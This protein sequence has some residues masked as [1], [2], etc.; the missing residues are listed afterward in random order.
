MSFLNPS[1]LWLS[2]LAVPLIALYALRVRP[3]RVEVATTMFWG[4]SHEQKPLRGVGNHLRDVVSLVLQL[5]LLALLTTALAEPQFYGQD[6]ATRQV[7][8]VLDN[9]ASMNATDVEP[10]RFEAARGEA[11]RLVNRLGAE[12][13]VAIITAGGAPRL[14]C[15][16]TRLR[17]R[18][19]RAIAEIQASQLP[20]QVG[21]ALL[22]AT[23][24]PS[25]GHRQVV[26][27]TDKPVEEVGQQEVFDGLSVIQVGG[28]TD[29]MAIT[30]FQARRSFNDPLG[31]QVLVA[32]QN[33]S[34]QPARCRLVLTLNGAMVD[35]VPLELSPG[36]TWKRVLAESAAEGG[37]LLARIEHEDALALDNSA[38][39]MLPDRTI[40]RVFL[41][42]P[43]N[44]FLKRVLEAQ[45][46]VELHVVDAIPKELAP[47]DV[48]VLHQQPFD[49]LP[50]GRVLVIEPV[51][52]TPDWNS[53]AL[54]D[55]P[56]VAD[57][58]DSLLLQHVDLGD[59]A[60]AGSRE[61]ELHTDAEILAHN[62]SGDPLLFTVRRNE[63]NALVM[64]LALE[65][66]DLPLRTAF[67]VLIANALTW[68]TDAAGELQDTYQLGEFVELPT[69]ELPATV[70]LRSP[71]GR[72]QLQE[73]RK[74]GPLIGP[75]DECGVWQI[76][77][78][79]PS[80]N[81]ATTLKLACNLSDANES[82]LLVEKV[83]R[84]KSASLSSTGLH[85]LWMYVVLATVC[86]SLTEWFLYHRRWIK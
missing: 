40:R 27:I 71:S 73:M 86:L 18:V 44:L 48:L 2:L 15:R 51:N 30:Q 83:D 1:A 77:V 23:E 32:V 26:V 67:P 63:G 69:N 4:T 62:P 13:E 65:Q 52:S 7:V 55:A 66:G 85:S 29:N 80:G 76:E 43:G 74:G 5:L 14:V 28:P 61:I 37:Q 57:Q 20:A 9:S 31:Y 59:V 68:L 19:R 72:E 46:Q 58:G 54:L 11:L 79:S 10:N 34:R 33:F 78:G 53:G 22:F 50:L 82:N 6:S 38:W 25:D 49:V 12:E 8:I 21:A 24:I 64:N 39:S 47:D 3:P 75:L 41:A 45:P 36:R 60:F 84:T 17:S 42:G 70:L 16:P 56:Y 81:T 35:V